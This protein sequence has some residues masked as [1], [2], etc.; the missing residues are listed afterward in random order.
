MLTNDEMLRICQAAQII[1]RE[2]TERRDLFVEIC[3]CADGKSLEPL[4]TLMAEQRSEPY[5]GGLNYVLL[6][7][8]NEES[9]DLLQR[10]ISALS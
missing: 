9:L 10:T 7:Y 3:R 8:T 5:N 2:A 4:W 6:S 1:F